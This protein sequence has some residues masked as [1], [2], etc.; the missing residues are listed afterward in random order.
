MTADAELLVSNAFNPAAEPYTAKGPALV[1]V[2]LMERRDAVSLS[3]QRAPRRRLGLQVPL[4]LPRVGRALAAA[5]SGAV[6]A[7]SAGWPGR[8][9]LCVFQL[10]AARQL[11]AGRGRGQGRG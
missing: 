6:V 4:R 10:G 5:G 1:V 3:I 2:R 9:T 11:R 8:L 7:A